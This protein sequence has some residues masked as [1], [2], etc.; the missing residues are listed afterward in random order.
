MR[1]V[2]FILLLSIFGTGLAL[3][4]GKITVDPNLPG[5]SSIQ[6]DDTEVDSRLD[7]KVTYEAK[8]K[9]VSEILEDLTKQT[10]VTLKAGQNSKDWESRDVKMCIFAR[11]LPLRKLMNSMARV[12]K[13][14][15]TREGKEGEYVYRFYMSERT[16]REAEER[17]IREE[18][19]R[20]KW[21]TEK[22]RKALESYLATATLASASVSPAEL[23]KLKTENPFLYA[24]AKAEILQPLTGLLREAPGAMDAIMTGQY[25]TVPATTLSP[26]GQNLLIKSMQNLRRFENKLGGMERPLSD[27]IAS[28]IDQAKISINWNLEELGNI[29]DMGFM[30]GMI[31]ISVGGENVHIPLIDPNSSIARFI[32][33]ALIKTE[34][35]VPIEEALKPSISD[36]EK[37]IR[38]EE[39]QTGEPEPEHPDE[40][41][42]HE[43]YNFKP[44]DNNFVEV[45][46]ELSKITG[47]SIVSDNYFSYGLNLGMM[48]G[49]NQNEERELK[50]ILDSLAKGYGYNWEKHGEVIEFQDKKWYQKRTALIP[51]DWIR[52]WREKLKKTGTLEIDDLAQIASLSPE[53]LRANIASE[54]VFAR[55]NLMSIYFVHKDTLRLYGALDENR[56]AV[57]FSGG[58]DLHLL[59]PDQLKL[60]EKLLDRRK[61]EYLSH[62]S[63]PDTPIIM[64]ASREKLDKQYRYSFIITVEA[65]D[66]AVEPIKWDILTP[67]YVEPSPKPKTENKNTGAGDNKQTAPRTGN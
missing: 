25:L 27:D 22:R 64:S 30:L 15:W 29:P 66:L 58:L 33:N 9:T 61:A 53:Q 41:A 18:E 55:A 13:F 28:K 11:D 7:Q 62:L 47:L 59:T 45:M 4:E 26:E 51:Q 67:L 1:K 24:L 16:R 38:S 42:L 36:I 56:R 40:P 34:E 21:L 54:E 46:A 65:Q 32:G 37:V 39:F 43:K 48:R 44:Q 35:G 3:A 14:R 31:R 52:A 17:R 20:Q 63:I 8:Q 49:K 57:L 12:M 50:D 19:N 5:A 10:G 6:K 23:E 2:A 60:A